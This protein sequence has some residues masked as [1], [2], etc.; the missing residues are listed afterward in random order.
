MLTID[1]LAKLD[2]IAAAVFTALRGGII[3]LDEKYEDFLI[4]ATYRVV[5][6]KARAVSKAEEKINALED[7]RN[8]L[9][10]EGAE[11]RERLLAQHRLA[12]S[13]LE[14]ELYEREDALLADLAQAAR[15]LVD[16]GKDYD[17]TVDAALV[18]LD[19]E[20]AK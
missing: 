15:S 13:A 10:A 6:A 12:L 16:A 7:S 3:W 20:I 4:G 9:V 1:R 18:K 5:E 14:D 19:W 2:A 11:A 8:A 17:A